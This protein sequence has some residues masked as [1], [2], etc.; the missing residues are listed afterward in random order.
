MRSAWASVS[1]G[2]ASSAAT[3]ARCEAQANEQRVAVAVA[4]GRVDEELA[5]RRGLGPSLLGRIGIEHR[6]RRGLVRCIGTD[7]R[8]ERPPRVVL[9]SLRQL[10]SRELDED[11]RALARDLGVLVA[12]LEAL[13]DAA[14]VSRLRGE[15][16]ERLPSGGVGRIDDDGALVLELRGDRIAVGRG[17]EVAELD[18]L[19]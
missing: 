15:P 3:A 18:E 7:G 19:L 2:L 1:S 13:D 17:Q 16:L 14:V 4:D 9:V 10:G 12:L 11:G 6:D 5:E 8:L